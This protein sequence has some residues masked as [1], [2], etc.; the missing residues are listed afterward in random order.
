ME[1][2]P[3]MRV[4]VKKPVRNDL[5]ALGLIVSLRNKLAHGSLSFAECGQ[6]DTP[7]ELEALADGIG[8]YLRVVVAAFE[9]YVNEYLYL[10]PESRPNADTAVA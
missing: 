6:D 2:Q 7:E 10:R 5:G 9:T 8:K 3:R 4:A 1:C